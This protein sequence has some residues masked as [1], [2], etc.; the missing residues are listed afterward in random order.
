MEIAIIVSDKDIAG[1]T[2]K[3]QLK[4]LPNNIAIHSVKKDSINCENIDKEI[5]ADVFVFATRHASSSKIPS[6][7]VHAPGNIGPAK[8]GGKEN[9][10]CVAAEPYIKRC[11]QILKEKNISGFEVIQEATHHGPYLEKPCFFI[12]LGSDENGWKNKDGGKAIAETIAE[13]FSSPKLKYKTAI[14][15]GGMHHSP[16]FAKIMM[17]D[18]YAI[19]HVCAKYN[20]QH[21]DENILNQMINKSMQPAEK[22]FLDW[23]GLGEHK[24][25]I[26]LLAVKS[27]IS[28][29]KV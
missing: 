10:L 3:E 7:T 13:C 22:I 25:K 27:G 17:E 29:E 2:I 24:E 26:K 23:K 15:I 11:F 1:L 16:G 28:W 5:T 8:Y 9:T 4:K 18:E 6:L 21:L 12:E 20:L 14:G 19:S